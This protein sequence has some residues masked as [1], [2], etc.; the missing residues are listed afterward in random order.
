MYSEK[1]KSRKE[2]ESIEGGSPR[3]QPIEPQ[4][5]RDDSGIPDPAGS[6]EEGPNLEQPSES[7]SLRR[8]TRQHKSPTYFKFDEQ[9]GYKRVSNY[10]R[11]MSKK[12]QRCTGKTY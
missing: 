5:R 11:L 7:P 10:I 2:G 4:L 8:S 9:R 3:Q 1:R 12:L 6:T